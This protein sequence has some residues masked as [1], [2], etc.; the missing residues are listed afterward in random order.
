MVLGAE[1]AALVGSILSGYFKKCPGKGKVGTPGATLGCSP[2]PTPRAGREQRRAHGKERGAGHESFVSDPGSLVPGQ[3]SGGGRL[4]SPQAVRNRRHGGRRLAACAG[5]AVGDRRAGSR[6]GRGGGAPGAAWAWAAGRLRG[7]LAGAAG[8]PGAC[9]GHSSWSHVHAECAK[10]ITGVWGSTE[11]GLSRSEPVRWF[12]TK[13]A[14]AGAMSRQAR[15]ARTRKAPPTVAA[16]LVWARRRSHLERETPRP[17]PVR[18][19][20]RTLAFRP[21]SSQ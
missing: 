1:A 19:V 12:L 16:V 17:V 6:A 11:Q 2:P 18:G 10:V 5:L 4:V 3:G 21:L 9:P 14:Q 8:G 20:R 13:T 7:T 15:A